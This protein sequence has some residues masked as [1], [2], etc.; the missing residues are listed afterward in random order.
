MKLIFWGVLW[1]ILYY[2]I[3]FSEDIR[4]IQIRA[5]LHILVIMLEYLKLFYWNIIKNLPN[6]SHIGESGL[7]WPAFFSNSIKTVFA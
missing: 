4:N 2:F 6:F 1:E 3:F 7:P 5:L